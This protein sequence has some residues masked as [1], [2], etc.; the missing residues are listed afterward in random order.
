[1]ICGILE[2]EIVDNMTAEE[3]FEIVCKIKKIKY[4]T[5]IGEL[6]N[7]IK[8]SDIVEKGDQ[9]GHTEIWDDEY[10]HIIKELDELFIY[11]TLFFTEEEAIEFFKD[12]IDSI[13]ELGELW[14]ET[15]DEEKEVIKIA[16][17]CGLSMISVEMM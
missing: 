4:E 7:R 3:K 8:D 10:V 15:T 16:Q 9:I 2:S 14:I 1:M 17:E 6:I 12:D 13:D 11:D 5:I